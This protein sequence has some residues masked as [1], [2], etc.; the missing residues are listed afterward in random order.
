M[1]DF[2]WVRISEL[3]PL[4]LKTMKLRGV[5]GTGEERGR[6]THPEHQLYAT[7]THHTPST[8]C[9]TPVSHTHTV[10]HQLHDTSI[11]HTHT[12]ALAV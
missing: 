1:N 10:K 3:F 8:S 2:L 12:L 5:A 11:S 4:E 9:M 6:L 7:H